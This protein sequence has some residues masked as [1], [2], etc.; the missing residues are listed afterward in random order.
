MIKL[1]RVLEK[2]RF[3]HS[4]SIGYNRLLEESG[5]AYSSETGFGCAQPLGH[6]NN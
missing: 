4:L 1:L 6:F 5:E 3:L 2:D